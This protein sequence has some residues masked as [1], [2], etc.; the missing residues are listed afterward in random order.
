MLKCRESESE[1]EGVDRNVIIV[2]FHVTK[3]NEQGMD[4]A[5][6]ID[7]TGGCNK[8]AVKVTY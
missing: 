3:C 7:T 2:M 4:K 1:S 5:C 6:P 8:I